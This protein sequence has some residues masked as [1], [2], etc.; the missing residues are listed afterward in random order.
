MKEKIMV[1]AP[2]PDDETFSCG[3]TIAKK[4][5]E[6]YEVIIVILTDGRYLLRIKFGIESAPS[7]EEVR[8]IR[9]EEIIGAMKILGVPMENLI[10]LDFKDGSLKE[11]EKKAEESI[12]KILE[13][14]SPVEVYF[15]YIKDFHPDHILTNRI[16]RR[17][18]QKSELKP[19]VLQYF[20]KHKHRYI[21]PIIEKVFNHFEMNRIEVNISEFLDLKE[22]AVMEFK[23]ELSI[24]SRKQKKPINNKIKKYLKKKEI[25]YIDK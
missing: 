22:K 14:Y 19:I 2:H 18:L 10:F 1:F 25:F 5:N 8:I 20:T 12:I 21:G 17:C 4:I 3:G 6:G 23:S 15:P 11:H 13:D 7:P 9:R 24:I 16:V